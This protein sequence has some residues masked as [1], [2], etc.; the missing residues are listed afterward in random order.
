VALGNFRDDGVEIA[1]GGA[2]GSLRPVQRSGSGGGS[3]GRSAEE[4][5][6]VNGSGLGV[7]G[8][9]IQILFI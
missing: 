7:R 8:P 2:T 4:G 6:T 1:C 3:K 5:A 9:L